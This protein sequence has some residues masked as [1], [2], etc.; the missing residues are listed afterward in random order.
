[1]GIKTFRPL[2]PGL[3]HRVQVVND[4]ITT[5]S[6]HPEKSLTWGKSGTGGRAAN[7]RISTR[8]KGGGHK[9]KIR[10]IDWRRDKFDVP[11]TVA[12]IEYDPN[13]SANIALLHYADGEK[14]YIIAPKGLAVGQ[15][16]LSG[17]KAPF[18]PGNALPSRTSRSA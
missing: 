17:T 18:E 15:T 10:L 6:S 12:S 1:M 9:R 7:G 8:H 14:R 11:A 13:R 3:R 4:E 5:N 16:L 2:T